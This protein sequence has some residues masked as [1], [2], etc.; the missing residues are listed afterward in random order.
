MQQPSVVTS[1]VLARRVHL[2]IDGF[3]NFSI[4]HLQEIVLRERGRA[5]GVTQKDVMG[6]KLWTCLPT[7]SG[8]KSAVFALWT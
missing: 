4:R 2:V 7:P 8:A 6:H 3:S 5:A 1:S